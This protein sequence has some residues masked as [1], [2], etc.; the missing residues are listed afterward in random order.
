MKYF[1]VCV[2]GT[3]DGLHAG[4][5]ALLVKAFE[6][7][8]HVLIGLTSDAYVAAHKRSSVKPYRMRQSGLLAWIQEKG[9][10]DRATIVSIDDPFEPAASDKTLDALVVSE[11]TKA[12]GEELNA[13]R[14][15]RNLSP[16][17]LVIAPTVHAQDRQPISTTRIR[18]GEIDRTGKLTMPEV[19]RNELVQPLGAVLTGDK[20]RASFHAHKGDFV[21]TVGDVTT[22]KALEAG[23]TPT[24]MMIDNKVNR[25][26]YTALQPL[27]R[28]RA[29]EKT[30]V[31][32]GPGFISASAMREVGNAMK[33]RSPL[34]IEVS[35]EEDLLTLPAIQEAPV[36]AVVYYGQ[37]AVP[38][39]GQGTLRGG[40]TEVIVSEERKQ[41][42]RN[43]LKQFVITSGS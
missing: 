13:L 7:G 34:V 26:A 24:L 25:Q 38:P 20:L 11:G 19:L 28:K 31:I 30:S 5:E 21:I 12:R 9:F 18:G 3:F 33:R 17:T 1:Y 10:G 4:H 42:V 41:H 43:L 14:T 35:G 37:P 22:Q 29:F 2:A 39:W 23:L 27:L 40:M 8:E 15:A 32:S 6:A 16:L 36:G